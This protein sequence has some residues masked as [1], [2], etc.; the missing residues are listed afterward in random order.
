M[1]CAGCG[2][3]TGKRKERGKPETCGGLKEVE[4]DD[5]LGDKGVKHR[6]VRSEYQMQCV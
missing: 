4:S 2:E 1:N 3:G 5:R 6:R